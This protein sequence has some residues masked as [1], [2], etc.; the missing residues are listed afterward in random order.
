MGLGE[1]SRAHGGGA[2]CLRRFETVQ[3]SRME[4]RAG[5]AVYRLALGWKGA[6]PA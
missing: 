6:E 3:R 1:S 2:A 4:A 5:G